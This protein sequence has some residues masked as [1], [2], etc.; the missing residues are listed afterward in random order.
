VLVFVWVCRVSAVVV[1]LAML[2][3][4]T[5][6]LGGY[7]WVGRVALSSGLLSSVTAVGLC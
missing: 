6:C 1:G 4:V 5:L 2:G 3:Y 7:V